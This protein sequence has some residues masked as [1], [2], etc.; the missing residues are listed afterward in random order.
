MKPQKIAI[1]VGHLGRKAGANSPYLHKS[2]FSYNME[3]A[4]NLKALDVNLYEIYTHNIIQPFSRQQQLANKLNCLNYDL[5]IE[6]H[7]NSFSQQANGTECLYC[8]GSIKGEKVAHAISNGIVAVYGTN[9]RQGGTLALKK[10]DR[11]YWFTY[12]PKAPAVIVEPFFGDNIE[13]LKFQDSNKY[14]DTLHSILSNLD[15]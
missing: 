9:L 4:N 1:V 11:G 7:F 2:E 5:V 13:A 10:G 12:L 15:L 3:V 14:A 6:L 8:K